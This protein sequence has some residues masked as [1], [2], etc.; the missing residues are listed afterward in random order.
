MNKQGLLR[1]E[2]MSL[3]RRLIE[4]AGED[5]GE[6]WIRQCLDLP[7]TSGQEAPVGAAT[8]SCF[9]ALEDGASASDFPVEAYMACPEEDGVLSPVRVPGRGRSSSVASG[10]GGTPPKRRRGPAQRFSPS[11]P[12]PTPARSAR[13]SRGSSIAPASPAGTSTSASARS[14]AR[15]KQAGAAVTGEYVTE[16]GAVGGVLQDA[17]SAQSEAASPWQPPTRPEGN[18]RSAGISNDGSAPLSRSREAASSQTVGESA[19]APTL[20][21]IADLLTTLIN[22]TRSVP[23]VSQLQNPVIDIWSPSSGQIANDTMVTNTIENSTLSNAFQL[24]QK[25]NLPETCLREPLSCEVSPLGY[26]LSVSMKEKIWR[27][28]FLDLLSLLP[29]VKDFVS[30]D[31]KEDEDRRR[32]VTRSFNNWLQAFCIFSAVLCEKFPEKSVGLFQ[33]IDIILEA[34]KSFG[35]TAWFQYDES[36]RQKIAVHSSLHWGVKD[37]GLWLNLFLPQRT[38]YTRQGQTP[39]PTPT[40]VYKK[41]I[42]FNFNDGQCK[43]PNSCRYR[44]ECAFCSGTHPV[45]KCFKKMSTSNQQ[46]GGF[47]KS[48]HASEMAKYAPVVQNVPRQAESSA[49]S[50]GI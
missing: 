11:P 34:F 50:G 8:D 3:L 5:C 47:P 26:H 46:P 29:S 38:N 25:Q 42:C 49:A 37:V 40:T 2:E 15:K 23:S 32:P 33:H 41:G 12:R 44:H 24:A 31:K 48:T 6:E 10:K 30:K 20:S 16:G 28:E 43:W 17:R 13:Q 1:P 35:G 45:A 39:Q 9:P 22:N 36:F 21:V 7:R 4:R 18:L 14:G 27:C 19:T